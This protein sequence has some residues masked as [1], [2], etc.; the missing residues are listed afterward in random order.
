MLTGG[1]GYIGAHVLRALRAAGLD[2]VV[3][4]DLSTGVR[5]K[6]PDGVPLVDASVLDGEAVADALVSHEVEGV[7]H[8]AAKKS[9]E[10]SVRAPLWYYHENVEGFRRLLAAMDVADVRRLVLSS[11]AAVYG[12]PDVDL[13]TEDVVCRPI[14]PYGQTKLICEWLA[15][16]AHRSQGLRTV[17]LRY[18]NVAGAGEPNL[19]DPG[20]ANLIPLA[21][22]ALEE[23]RSPIVFGD[24]YPTPDGTCVRDYIHVADLADAHVTAARVLGAAGSGAAGNGPGGDGPPGDGP[25]RHGAVYNISRG[26][27]SS[28]REVLDVAREV[29]GI[30]LP[31]RVAERRV[32]DPPR[33]VGAADAIAADLGWRARH[34]LR[35][36]VASAWEARRA[37]AFVA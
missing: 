31:A 14:N 7:I 37:A 6:L 22:R 13:V 27:G 17:T 19:G 26:V 18:F 5:A 32:G 15:A 11:S 12:M 2:V 20:T 35:D 29:T 28:V 36:M 8:L 9:V 33:L 24:D 30:A 16:D 21:L 3:L 10:E 25:A 34:D 4:D 1:A 23:S